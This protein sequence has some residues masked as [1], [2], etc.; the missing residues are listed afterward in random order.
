[1]GSEPIARGIP[2]CLHVEKAKILS[3]RRRWT[4]GWH[5][6]PNAL[7]VMWTRLSSCKP[8]TSVPPTPMGMPG[9]LPPG[10]SMA[11]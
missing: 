11:D 8:C 6:G 7:P 2:G 10:P 9:S 3:V 4:I 5:A 1:M